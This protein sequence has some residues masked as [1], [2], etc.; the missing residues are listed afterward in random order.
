[1]K[2]FPSLLRGL[3]DLPVALP[4]AIGPAER[5]SSQLAQWSSLRWRIELKT[6]EDNKYAQYSW[7]PRWYTRSS[8]PGPTGALCLYYGMVGTD[9]E[10]IRLVFS[11][12]NRDR[13]AAYHADWDVLGDDITY[14][15]D[16]SGRPW[17]E[18]PQHPDELSFSRRPFDR[19]VLEQAL[20]DMPVVVRALVERLAV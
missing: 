20:N 6:S 10:V 19:E 17:Y 16:L 11:A 2:D 14:T 3:C 12:L 1:M 18:S 8:G 13:Q 4:R 15:T 9:R 7:T 5:V